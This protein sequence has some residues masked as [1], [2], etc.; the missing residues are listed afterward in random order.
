MLSMTTIEVLALLL[1]VSL[2]LHL[3]TAAALASR[4]SG[5]HPAHAL[6]VGASTTATAMGLY[7]SAVVVY[8]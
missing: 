7:L 2:G 4:S 5:A 6:L 3:G 1:A 8:R